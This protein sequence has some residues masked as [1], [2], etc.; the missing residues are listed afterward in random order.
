[1]TSA[2]SRSSVTDSYPPFSSES[3]VVGPVRQVPGGFGDAVVV[4]VNA[5]SCDDV[6]DVVQT[7][8]QLA[9][10]L[11]VRLVALDRGAGYLDRV[12]QHHLRFRVKPSSTVVLRDALGEDQVSS[13]APQ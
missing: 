12:V 4:V 1:M 3:P 2:L 11:Y 8:T 13:E 9:Q 5:G 10:L 7:K 6:V